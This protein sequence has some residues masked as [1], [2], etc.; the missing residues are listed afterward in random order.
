MIVFVM[1]EVMID[2]KVDIFF[3]QSNEKDRN[4]V[5][6]FGDISKA[7]FQEI[8]EYNEIFRIKVN[9]NSSVDDKNVLTKCIKIFGVWEREYLFKK[10][11]V[12]KLITI[13]Q[14]KVIKFPSAG[15]NHIKR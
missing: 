4:F 9:M 3:K 6:A 15:S 14:N 7:L 1:H 8:A 13:I 12:Q 5:M 2:T 10:E 11:F